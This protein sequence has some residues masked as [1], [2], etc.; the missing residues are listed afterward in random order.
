VLPDLPSSAVRRALAAELRRLREHAGISGDEVAARL[1][2]SGSKVSRIET[3]RTGIKPNDLEQLLDLYDVEAAQRNQLRALATEQEGRGWWS[4]YT[5]LFSPEFIAY[6][7][8][9]AAASSIS[10]WS[11]EL[12][13]GLLQTEDY[14]RAALDV[15]SGL[16]AMIPPGEMQR[17]IDARLRRQ[18]ILSQ[19]D[20]GKFTF[21]LDEAAL[22]HRFGTNEIMQAQ[23]RQVIQLARLP[24]VSVR[25]L[26]FARSH[27]IGPGGFALLEFAPLHGTK[28]SDIVY[29][30]HLTRS[31]F[32]EEEA[33]TFEYRLAF[34][35]LLSEALDEEASGKLI[36][37]IAREMW[38]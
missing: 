37:R 26:A 33:E 17:R 3:H 9:E 13:H 4:A 32:L 11:P 34:G 28:P 23:L 2:W 19:P 16:P 8:L 14:A 27:P 36:A 1:G 29:M 21:V 35:R 12:I 25:V 24:N 38:I 5:S 22:R 30:E 10:C 6:I 31:S 15:A 18:E 7:G 20:A